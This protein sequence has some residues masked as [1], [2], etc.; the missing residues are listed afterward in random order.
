MSNRFNKKRSDSD[1][2]R[3]VESVKLAPLFLLRITFPK[4]FQSQNV[5]Q[6]FI[7]GDKAYAYRQNYALAHKGCV[8]LVIGLNLMSLA[9]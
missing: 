4:S 7:M 8:G 5:I 3:L 9:F 2:K 1:G 6:I